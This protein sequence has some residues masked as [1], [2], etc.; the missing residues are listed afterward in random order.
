MT[1]YDK[2]QNSFALSYL[3]SFSH[4]SFCPSKEHQTAN[5]MSILINYSTDVLIK[6][7]SAISVFLST[8]LMNTIECF[9]DSIYV[10]IVFALNVLYF[11]KPPVKTYVNLY[12]L[13]ISAL[14]IPVFPMNNN[15]IDDILFVVAI[16]SG[17]IFG[18]I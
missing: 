3:I 7:F 2:R 16:S 14:A 12:W 1:D 8:K 4:F 10:L 15:N 17:C 9:Y 11:D 18:R 13:L 6:L 5:K